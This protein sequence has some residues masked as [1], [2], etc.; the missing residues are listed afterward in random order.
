MN[1]G[2]KYMIKNE[3]NNEEFK[4][5]LEYLKLIKKYEKNIC[6]KCIGTKNQK[7]R[8]CGILNGF[9]DLGC[10]YMTKA[11]T[12]KMKE[13][14]KLLIKKVIAFQIFSNIEKVA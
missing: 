1:I 9:S 3:I 5:Y 2:L 7:K 8:G 14:N 4:L 6:S 12:K 11:I 10:N 13:K